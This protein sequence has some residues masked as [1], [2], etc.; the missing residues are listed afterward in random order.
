M[1]EILIKSLGKRFSLGV[2]RRLFFFTRN[3]DQ[4]CQAE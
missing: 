2:Q 4:E 1:I 3:E